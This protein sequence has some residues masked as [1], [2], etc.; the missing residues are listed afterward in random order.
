MQKEAREIVDKERRD[1]KLSENQKIIFNKN[2]D[3]RFRKA[4]SKLKDENRNRNKHMLRL[5][6]IRKDGNKID[7]NKAQQY[8]QFK[9]TF[10]NLNEGKDSENN[11]K[12][13]NKNDFMNSRFHELNCENENLRHTEEKKYKNF[14]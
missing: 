2:I 7:R 14:K 6:E 12:T 5:M 13:K 9:I 3:R 10:E 1:I 4:M 11:I 8:K